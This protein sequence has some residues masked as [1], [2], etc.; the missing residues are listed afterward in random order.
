MGVILK[1]VPQQFWGDLTDGRHQLCISDPGMHAAYAADSVALPLRA[2]VKRLSKP[3]SVVSW[4]TKT[5]R[6][7]ST[8]ARF[9]FMSPGFR[10]VSNSEFGDKWFARVSR[11]VAM[12]HNGTRNGSLA[13]SVYLIYFGRAFSPQN[14][15]VVRLSAK[16]AA[17][18]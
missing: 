1:T 6:V 7:R 17:T 4:R 5:N 2:I 11:T 12:H 3:N 16:T 14:P 15:P 10:I 18:R 8:P 9:R 13:Y